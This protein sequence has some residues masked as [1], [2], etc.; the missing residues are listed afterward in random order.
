MP[1]DPDAAA[2][3]GVRSWRPFLAVEAGTGLSGAA[4]GITIVALPWLVLERT[5]SATAA[6]VLAAITAVPTMIAALLSGTI[7]DKAGRRKVSVISDILS[8]I[9]VALIPIVDFA[10]GLDFGLLAILAVLGAIFDPAGM[11]AREAMVPE[12]A[13]AA[14]LPL[15]KA[16]GIHEAVWGAAYVIGPALGGVLIA[17]IGAAPTFWI[18]AMMFAASTFAIAIVKIPGGGKPSTTDEVGFWKSTSEGIVFVWRDRLQ[19]ALA[20]LMAALVAIWLPV[21]GVLLPVFYEAQDAPGRLGLVLMA[22]SLGM[23]AGAL[24][25]GWLSVRIGNLRVFW[26][27]LLFTALGILGLSS[28]PDLAWMIVLSIVVG[29]AFGPIQPIL[30][31][32]MQTRTPSRLRGRVVGLLT[33]IQYAAGPIG[34]LLVGPL[35]DGVGIEWAFP[36]I[37][38]AITV[39]CLVPLVIPRFRELSTLDDTASAPPPLEESQPPRPLS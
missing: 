33:A 5:G 31:V 13:E 27:A 11:G 34:F 7:V 15:A 28:L 10:F 26:L 21:E 3:S 1:S 19:R 25:Y 23:I 39:I 29:I 8:L 38:V 30:N 17:V 18:T 22:M 37:A 14:R 35:V 20:I 9:S 24:A 4:N 32:A 6:G 36:I 2:L 12:A 16:N